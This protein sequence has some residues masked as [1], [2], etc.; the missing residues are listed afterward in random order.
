[1]IDAQAAAG[2]PLNYENEV[3]Y[4]D[5]PTL[6]LP[7][8]L[9]RSGTFIAIE[10]VGDS[11][12]PTIHSKDWLIARHLETPLEHLREGYVHVVVTEEGVVAKRLYRTEGYPGFTLRSDNDLYPP[13]Q[14]LFSEVLQLY[15]VEALFS[16]NLTNR[17]DGWQDRLV[18]LERE[19]TAMK[20]K[21]Q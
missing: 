10:A 1:M 11:M 6:K 4:K 2:L 3:Y 19:V 17:R 21:G 9:Y 16:E 18:R 7:G 5:K 20:V 13:Y 12:M 8:Q 15:R 14:V